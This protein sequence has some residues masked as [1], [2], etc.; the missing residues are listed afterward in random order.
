[1]TL[2]AVAQRLGV[3][4]PSLYNHI[5]GLSALRSELAVRGL[6]LLQQRLEQAQA[7]VQGEAALHAFAQAYVAFADEHPGLYEASLRVAEPGDEEWQQAGQNLLEMIKALLK[8]YSLPS[9]EHTHA[10]RGL[11]SILHGF[12]DLEHK[13][14]FMQPISKTDSLIYIMN[15]YIAGLSKKVIKSQPSG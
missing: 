8:D 9:K 11:R 5:D 7:G 4:S 14:A 12:C 1:M 6:N 13:G 3:R 15:A 10:I 2:A